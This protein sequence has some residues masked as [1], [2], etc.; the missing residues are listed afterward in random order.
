MQIKGI[1]VALWIRKIMVFYPKIIYL[2]KYLSKRDDID[3][4][5]VDYSSSYNIKMVPMNLKTDKNE[6][7][8]MQTIKKFK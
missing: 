2:E 8:A 4:I 6:I 3:N 5:N 7:V 1:I